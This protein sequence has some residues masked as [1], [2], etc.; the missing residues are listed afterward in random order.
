MANTGGAFGY[1][2]RTQL[3]RLFDSSV[4]CPVRVLS[5]NQYRAV[6]PKKAASNRYAGWAAG[7]VGPGRPESET[8]T[9]RVA[10]RS[11]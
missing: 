10:C 7:A 2:M 1:R 8:N 5:H 6:Q 4:L 9:Q 11:T 3:D